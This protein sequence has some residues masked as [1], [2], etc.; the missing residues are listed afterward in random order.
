MIRMTDA[1]AA[2]L[3][4]FHAR[5]LGLDPVAMDGQPGLHAGCRCARETRWRMVA[6]A[7]TH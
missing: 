6:G 5:R 4:M 3:F 7:K 2:M 1:V